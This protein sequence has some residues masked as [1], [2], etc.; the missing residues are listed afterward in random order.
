MASGIAEPWAIGVL[1]MIDGL[2]VAS[3]CALM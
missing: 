2:P 3:E 1:A